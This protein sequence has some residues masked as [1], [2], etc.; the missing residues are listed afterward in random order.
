[1]TGLGVSILISGGE[2]PFTM[3]D[4]NKARA[5]HASSQCGNTMSRTR[6]PLRFKVKKD[7]KTTPSSRPDRY[8]DGRDLIRRA[9]GVGADHPDHVT[10]SHDRDGYN[11]IPLGHDG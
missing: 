8:R 11:V 6:F 1:M 4:E 3:R 2:D 9:A 7:L 10:P 5:K